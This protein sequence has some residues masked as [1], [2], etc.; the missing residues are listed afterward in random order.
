M[1]EVWKTI[2]GLEK[3]E[4][5]SRGRIKS[6]AKG[7]EKILS[8]SPNNRGYRCFSANGKPYKV[9]RVVALTFGIIEKKDMV[10]HKDGIKLNNNISNLEK[11]NALHNVRHSFEMGLNKVL[12][13][14]ESSNAKLKRADVKKIIKA[15]AGDELCKDIA[16]R[17]DVCVA[18]ISKIGRGEY[19]K[20]FDDYRLEL[21]IQS[22]RLRKS[23]KYHAAVG[24]E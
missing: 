24:E 9:H 18:L 5:S 7:Y 8:C 3:Y 11:S 20:E 22:R 17:F 4:A 6:F 15:Y 13:G 1:K 2:V 10:N 21:G 16:K 12:Y 14:E 19:W 23:A